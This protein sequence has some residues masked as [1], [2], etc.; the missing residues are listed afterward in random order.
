M[1]VHVCAGVMANLSCQLDIPGKRESQMQ[2][3]LNQIGLLASDHVCEARKKGRTQTTVC[4]A[5]RRY[6]RKLADSKQ[7]SSMVTASV[8]ASRFLT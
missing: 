1:H 4:R 7:Q 6:I 8:P 2:N 3:F 5:I